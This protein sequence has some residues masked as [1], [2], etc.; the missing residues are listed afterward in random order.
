[1]AM[2]NAKKEVILVLN[3]VDLVKPKTKLLEITRELVSLINGIKLKKEDMD[4]AELD[5]TTF[6]ISG[7]KNDGVL[8]IKNYLISIA[9]I[10]A[11]TIPSTD[12][13]TT[14]S[15]N[16]RIEQL[17]LEA[18]LNHTHE[19][20]PYIADIVCTKIEKSLHRD[21][22]YISIKVDTPQQQRICVGFQGRTMLKIRQSVSE[23][24]ER[25][26]KKQ[27]LVF[28][29]IVVSNY[30]DENPENMQQFDEGSNINSKK[31]TDTVAN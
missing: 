10:K 21:R 9:D 1:M 31:L 23:D 19:E 17:A 25:I 7:L 15:I 30:V 29:N 3:K 12:G 26:L 18:M 27:V 16:Q 5:T 14:L 22:V 24:L 8:D 13:F 28:I 6:M 11:W 20:I 4:K 2:H